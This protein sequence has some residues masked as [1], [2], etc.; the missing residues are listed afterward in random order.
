LRAYP[1]GTGDS[2]VER[3]TAA[4]GFSGAEVFRV[5]LENRLYCLRCWPAAG[6]TPDR[7]RGLHRLLQTVSRQGGPPVAVPLVNR[8]GETLTASGQHWWQLEPWLP[9]QADYHQ[10]PSPQRLSAAM[11]ALAQ[12][13]QA[14]SH[15]HPRPN[16]EQWFGSHPAA[17]SPAVLERIERLG[18]YS[19]SAQSLLRRALV[20][21]PTQPTPEQAEFCELG[22]RGLTAAHRLIPRVH[23]EL[24]SLR[25]TLFRLQPC[26]RDVWHDHVL[27]QGETVSGLIDASACRHD[28]VATDIARLVSSLIAEDRHGW[29]AAL[30]AYQ[31]QRTLDLDE[32]V[33]VWALDRSGTLLSCLSWIS[34]FVHEQL[35]PG[36]LPAVSTR[37]AAM[38]ARLETW[39]A[40][41]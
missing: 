12:W 22:M 32:Q 9:G 8:D 16:E 28:H 39:S 14:A 21:R 30:T 13:H 26:L 24:Q 1:A 33:L 20:K 5:R 19:M 15:F 36:W 3:P 34:R 17:P 27:F 11:Q 4:T 7:I 10:R 40:E 31:T 25:Q 35:P 37:V 2:E 41:C 6:L 38:I 29:D 18:E 23:Q